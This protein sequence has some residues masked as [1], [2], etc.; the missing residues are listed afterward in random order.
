MRVDGIHLPANVR[1]MVGSNDNFALGAEAFLNH[2]LEIWALGK[3]ACKDNDLW[4]LLNPNRAAM[5]P[6]LIAVTC[7]LCFST[8]PPTVST[9]CSTNGLKKVSA[10]ELWDGK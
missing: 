3:A 10:V 2:K 5:M 4:G 8:N 1:R 7:I 9:T 6:K